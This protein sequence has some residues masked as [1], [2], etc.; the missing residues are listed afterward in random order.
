MNLV[1]VFGINNNKFMEIYRSGNGGK[2]SIDAGS[3]KRVNSFN[4][5]PSTIVATASTGTTMS[6]NLIDNY[7]WFNVA[8]TSAATDFITLPDCPVGTVIKMYAVS[9][10]KV[11]GQ[12]SDTINGVAPTTDITLAADSVSTL[13]KTSAT[14]WVLLQQ[15]S[16]GAVTAP[17]V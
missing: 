5:Y 8:Q 1:V 13:T 14:A 3:L 9:A 2:P 16:A 10:C 15:S 6:R 17:I 11:Q 12:G 7:E 4:V